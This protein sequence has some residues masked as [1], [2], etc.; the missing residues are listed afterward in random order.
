MDRLKKIINDSFYQDCLSK[1][2]H[3]ETRRRYCRHD[4]K[5]MMD[6]S[7]ISCKIME[8]SGRLNIMAAEAGLKDRNRARE[9]VCAA[10]LLHDIARWIQYDTGE[11]HA[12]AGARLAVGVLVRAGFDD[13]EIKTVVRA[14][15]EHRREMPD[16]SLLGFVLFLA[17]D[18]SRD[19]LGCR[20]RKDCH[21]YLQVEILKKAAQS[22]A[23]S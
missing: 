11:D 5:H 8:E 9:V 13:A 22:G 15:T 14:I 19:C 1:N 18:L 4:L 2:A 12:Q 3:R 21:K 6:V 16:S 20:A 23:L 7:D 10:A 17:D